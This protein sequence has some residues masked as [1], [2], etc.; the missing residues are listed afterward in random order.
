MTCVPGSRRRRGAAPLDPTPH[1]DAR[2]LVIEELRRRDV[3]GDGTTARLSLLDDDEA[4]R[5]SGLRA[6]QVAIRAS[7][8]PESVRL[9]RTR[10]TVEAALDVL[11]SHGLVEA[12]VLE[13]LVCGTTPQ[14][15]RWARTTTTETLRRWAGP[16]P[17]QDS[18]RSCS[19]PNCTRAAVGG[20]NYCS[21]ACVRAAYRIRQA[22]GAK[23]R[24]GARGGAQ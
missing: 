2:A 8:A 11:V 7:R 17:A 15:Y 13:G 4:H 9:P 10:S 21:H 22:A 24:R 14:R 3:G 19:A 1:D 5:A 16:G 23:R 6:G 20:S 12:L 18:A